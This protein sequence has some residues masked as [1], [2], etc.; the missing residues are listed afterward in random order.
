MKFFFLEH[1]LDGMF[2]QKEIWS[3]LPVEFDAGFIVP[4]DPA[5]Q[6]RAVVQYDDHRGL[7]LH[8]LE[9]ISII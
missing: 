8:L 1:E 6:F 5:R 9:V 2:E 7:I 4:L 3:V